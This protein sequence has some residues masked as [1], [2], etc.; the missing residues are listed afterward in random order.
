MSH[1]ASRDSRPLAVTTRIWSSATTVATHLYGDGMSAKDRLRTFVD[2]LSEDEAVVFLVILQ[3]RHEALELRRMVE[4]IQASSGLSEQ[5]A[6]R[7][8]YNELAAS[9]REPRDIR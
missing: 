7:I 9:R 3:R 4:A 5:D 2:G 1:S 8:A 6:E